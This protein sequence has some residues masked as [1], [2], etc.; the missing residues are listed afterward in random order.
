MQ[1][2]KP[3]GFPGFFV[4]CL[5]SFGW[6]FSFG[7]GAPLA[8]LWL[9]DAGYSHGLAGVNTG[10][11]YLGIAVTALFIPPLMTRLQRYCPAAGM[12]LSGVAVA[13]FPFGGGPPGWLILRAVNGIGGAMSLIPM[14]T[15]VNQRSNPR[16]RA[17]NFGFYALS[18]ALGIGL[19]NVA[20]LNL[21][22][23]WPC[24]A[25]LLGG[26]ASAAAGIV[27][28]VWLPGEIR[29]ADVGR[30]RSA[31]FWRRNL[32]GF[33][34]AW[35]QGFLEGGMIAFLPGFLAARGL[36]DN[37]VGLL[38]GA[39]ML[40]VIVWQLPVAWLAD[41]IGRSA[42]LLGCY[43]VTLAGTLVL[44]SS[45][46]LL[47][48][49]ALLFLVGA[50]SAAF[51]PLGLALVGERTPASGVARASA[52]FLG[53]NSLGSCVGPV[54]AGAAMDHWG[55]EA[56]FPSGAA[57]VGTVLVVCVANWM[58]TRPQRAGQAIPCPDV[59]LERCRAA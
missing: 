2:A 47:S 42:V 18:V 6:S 43:A 1:V 5:T 39:T 7:L 46:G 30:S 26:I 24:L 21:Y 12:L 29:G 14:E 48:L 41:R 53:I 51:Y 44:P 49:A 33:G 37:A 38:M 9:E 58:L 17:R 4:L 40:G 50:C 31:I 52:C 45:P 20:G 36:V 56:L 32:F 15:L 55:W 35:G 16:Q 27:V 57:A 19:G 34:S 59:K 8:S 25:F 3:A 10:V 11:Y 54:V 13:L 23:E 28:A 22:R